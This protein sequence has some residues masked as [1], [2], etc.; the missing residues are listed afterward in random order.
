VWRGQLAC[1]S[2][3]YNISRVLL[4]TRG[5]FIRISDHR[6][7]SLTHTMW[8]MEMLETLSGIPAAGVV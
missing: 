6:I 5:N 3:F 8:L 2:A 4:V 1:P 7:I